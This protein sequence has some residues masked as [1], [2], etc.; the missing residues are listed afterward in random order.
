MSA[1]IYIPPHISMHPD[2]IGA[3]RLIRCDECSQVLSIDE[4]EVVSRGPDWFHDVLVAFVHQHAH[5]A[6]GI[7]PQHMAGPPP[8]LIMS[9]LAALTDSVLRLSSVAQENDELRQK[10]HRIEEERDKA[11]SSWAAIAESERARAE[12]LKVKLTRLADDVEAVLP[13]ALKW[14]DAEHKSSP[15]WEAISLAQASLKSAK[16]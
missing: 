15:V 5:G 12:A 9:K 11:C 10:L 13:F 7:T 2:N 3:F 14:A 4:M 16:E 6:G 1:S 8:D